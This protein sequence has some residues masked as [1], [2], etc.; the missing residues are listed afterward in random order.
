M[1]IC[2][3]CSESHEHPLHGARSRVYPSDLKNIFPT[4]ADNST[5]VIF[6]LKCVVCLATLG[7]NTFHDIVSRNFSLTRS[8]KVHEIQVS[9]VFRERS[10]G[11]MANLESTVRESTMARRTRGWRGI[12]L[13]GCEEVDQSKK[14]VK[15]AR[16]C[17]CWM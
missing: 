5:R 13:A 2:C 3:Y 6:Y 9:E 14:D 8:Q 15:V 11:G 4:R 12:V 16:P 1:D 10:K 7:L 17:S